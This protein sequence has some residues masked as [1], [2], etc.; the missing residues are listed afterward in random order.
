MDVIIVEI[1]MTF[2]N[3][4][5]IILVSLAFVQIECA[6]NKYEVFINEVNINDPRKPERREFIELRSTSKNSITLQGYKL[7]GISGGVHADAV[8]VIELVITLWNQ[9]INANGFFTVGGSDVNGADLRIPS[10]YIKFRNNFITGTITNFLINGN[11]NINAI[12]LLY[13]RQESFRDIVLT[14]QKNHIPLDGKMKALLKQHLVDMVVYSKMYDSNRCDIY[15]EIYP[16]F[17]GRKYVLR[18]FNAVD[19]DYTLNRCASESLGFRPEKFKI[20][21]PTPGADNDCSGAHYIVED[22]ILDIMPSINTHVLYPADH[23]QPPVSY[24]PC[25]STNIERTEYYMHSSDK[26][27]LSIQTESEAAQADACTPHMLNPY[28]GNIAHQ[29]DQANN[30]KRRISAIR[31]Y[32]EEFEWK[33]NKYFKY[34]R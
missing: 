14:K 15:E 25:C 19:V 24:E 32:S 23:E 26:I 34:V 13:G 6:D 12:G 9:H 29:I 17:V 30:R 21:K 27:L 8:P 18:E 33:T 11:K 3:V 4:F 16:Q 31:D 5:I 2:S 22:R 28:G 20:G 7:I 1:K 10:G